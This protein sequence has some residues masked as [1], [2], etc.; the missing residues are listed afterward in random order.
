[1]NDKIDL[2]IKYEG[3]S[4]FRPS[5]NGCYY[6]QYVTR[7]RAVRSVKDGKSMKSTAKHFNIP[8]TTLASWCKKE[9]V[10]SSY[11]AFKQ[12]CS[13][14]ML[15]AFIRKKGYVTTKELRVHFG[16]SDAP[17]L[18]RLRRLV[19]EGLLTFEKNDR[20]YWSVVK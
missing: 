1:M 13:D 11:P 6:H 19:S 8:L 9:G 15:M 12:K 10:S 14:K 7:L 17:L 20:R 3:D 5:S 16:Y 2:S 18:K 4:P